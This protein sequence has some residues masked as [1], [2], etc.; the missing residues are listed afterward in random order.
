MRYGLITKLSSN[1]ERTSVFGVSVHAVQRATKMC[2]AALTNSKSEFMVK[3][4][5]RIF[6]H[7]LYLNNEPFVDYYYR[8]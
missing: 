1:I 5:L 2:E 8:N 3:S 7:S 6:S 4:A